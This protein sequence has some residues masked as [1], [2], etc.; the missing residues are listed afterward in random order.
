[1]LKC[2]HTWNNFVLIP[3]V[4]CFAIT[5]MSELRHCAMPCE[6]GYLHLM[7]LNVILARSPF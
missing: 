1:M 3:L 2:L 4:V 5:V 6:K 7:K